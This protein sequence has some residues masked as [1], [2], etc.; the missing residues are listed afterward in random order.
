[1]MTNRPLNPPSALSDGWH[2]A[3]LL[4]ISEEATPD[5]WQMHDQSPRMWRWSFATWESPQT[6]QSEPEVQSSLTST[7]FSPKSRFP[8]SKSYLWACALL[9]RVIQRGETVSFDSLDPLP[10]R[11]KTEKR[12]EGD[13]I[14]VLELEP[15]PEGAQLLPS[16]K[17]MLLQLR[18]QVRQQPP[19]VIP[20]LAPQQPPP[21]TAAAQPGPPGLQTWG[22]VT[23]PPASQPPSRRF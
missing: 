23:T 12:A 4:H 14:K 8:A 3:Y 1:M 16:L 11:I 18:E 10:C 20:P 19:P 9:G 17:A 2:P 13:F 6:M 15:W 7:K 22:T 5:D 21:A